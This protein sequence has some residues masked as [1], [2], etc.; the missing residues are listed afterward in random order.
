MNTS[1]PGLR[2]LVNAVLLP[3]L[4]GD[5]LDPWMVDELERGLGGVCWFVGEQPL[6]VTAVAAVMADVHAANPA[7]VV[8]V[9]EEGGTVTRLETAAG[10]STPGAAALGVYD[11]AGATAAV[12]AAIGALARAAGC[13]VVLAPDVDVNSEPRNPVIGVRA[14]GS[15]PV[16]VARHGVAFVEGVQSQGVAA[17]AKH[18]PGH[19]D[20]AVD[21]HLGLPTV[22]LTREQFL[23]DHLAPFGAVID[24][25]VKS[26]MSAHVVVPAIDDRPATLSLEWMRILRADLGFDGVMFSDALDMRAISGGIGRAAGAVAALRAGCDVLCIGNP[27]FPERYDNEQITGGIRS[28]VIAAVADGELPLARL[29]EAAGRAADLAGWVRAAAPVP[30]DREHVAVVAR[31]VAEAA[32]HATG[33][34]A[35]AGPPLVL[36]ESST[37]MAAGL[38][39][40][41]LLTALAG[42]DPATRAAPVTAGTVAAL[43][44]ATVNSIAAAATADGLDVATAS[45]VTRG[46]GQ[47]VSVIGPPG[48]REDPSLSATALGGAG[49]DGVLLVTDGLNGPAVIEA[50]RSRWPTAVV[51][52]VG[53]PSLAADVAPPLIVTNG[54]SAVTASVTAELLVPPPL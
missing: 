30:L 35:R 22:A 43:D 47:E 45:V 21:S 50:V 29:E 9:D 10:S 12:A 41:P 17:C 25:G 34:V 28:A 31:Q 52:H 3:G 20:T 7:A 4:C 27:N 2:R 18:F 42:R 14:F 13:D 36:L 19:G 49:G 54:M 11:D 33:D 8:T 32:V 37:N 5:E 6:D 48:D 16:L 39:R 15:D 53:A 46:P 44:I 23:R 51:V 40:S 26:L 1:D 38:G 24:A